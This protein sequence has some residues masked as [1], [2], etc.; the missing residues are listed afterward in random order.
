MSCP[1][2]QY[3]AAAGTSIRT[4]KYA[5]HSRL[6]YAALR[7]DSLVRAYVMGHFVPTWVLTALILEV[8]LLA[9]LLTLAM[10]GG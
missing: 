2:L 9:S 8:V 10:A 4:L 3:T 6:L 7:E 1:V 5:I